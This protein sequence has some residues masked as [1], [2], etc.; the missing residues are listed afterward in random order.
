ML[1]QLEK[2]RDGDIRAVAGR[3]NRTPEAM[4]KAAAMVDAKDPMYNQLLSSIEIL[5]ANIQRDENEL[6]I[7]M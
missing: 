2:K 7:Y 3:G 5:K 6:K 4:A 1:K